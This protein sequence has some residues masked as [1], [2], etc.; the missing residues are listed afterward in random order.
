MQRLPRTDRSSRASVGWPTWVA[1]PARLRFS[2]LT[3]K[4]FTRI[5]PGLVSF[6]NPS[7]PKVDRPKRPCC[8]P[9]GSGPRYENRTRFSHGHGRGFFNWRNVRQILIPRAPVYCRGWCVG[10][11]DGPG[12]LPAMAKANYEEQGLAE[13]ARARAVHDRERLLSPDSGD[14]ARDPMSH[15][16]G[17]SFGPSG[18]QTSPLLAGVS[19][20]GQVTVWRSLLRC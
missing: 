16:L 3:N 5:R 17:D 4:G 12:S 8:R 7:D 14:R 9:V 15:S 20:S 10:S 1:D 18:S 2:L 6:L 11:P 19:R 13:Q